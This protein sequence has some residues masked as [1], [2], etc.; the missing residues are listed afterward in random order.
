VISDV[1]GL[2]NDEAARR[3][4]DIDLDAI[5]KTQNRR[6]IVDA[7]RRSVFTLFNADLIGIA[8][9]MAFLQ[10]FLGVLGAVLVII[11]N[12][13]LNAGQ[14]AFARVQMMKLAGAVRPEI[15]VVREG[16]LKTVPLTRVVRGDIVVAGPGDE[17]SVG[18]TVVLNE[19]LKVDE[20][21]VGRSDPRSVD[22]GDV[23]VSGSFVTSGH[24]LYESSEAGLAIQAER[25]HEDV[26]VYSSD[27]TALQR[28]LRGVLRVL[29]A[30][31]IIF[32]VAV[33]LDS[34]ISAREIVSDEYRDAFSIVFG[35]AP[36]SLF[37]ILVV[38][39]AMGL[40]RIA[41]HGAL[42][43]RSS[44]V[45]TL[46]GVSVICASRSSLV[47][48]LSVKLRMIETPEDEKVVSRSRARRVLGDL[49]HTVAAVDKTSQMLRDAID[50]EERTVTDAVSLLTVRGWSG[51]SFDEQDIRGTVVLGRPEILAD[52]L[53]WTPDL[54]G[55]AED[56][57]ADVLA[58]SEGRGV[59]YR[60]LT[61]LQQ[62]LKPK[63]EI[64]EEAE[65]ERV[66]ASAGLAGTTLVLAYLPAKTE[67]AGGS[68][69][70][71]LPDGL[72][73]LA[74]VDVAED[75]RPEARR[76]LG[77]LVDAGIAIKIV[78]SEPVEYVSTTVDDL[79]VRLEGQETMSGA[80][81]SDKNDEELAAALGGTVAF[82]E[83]SAAQKVRV[84]DALKTDGHTVAML[85]HSVSDLA[86]MRHADVS[87]AQLGSD[88]GVLLSA[89]IVLLKES[90]SALRRTLVTGQRIV[91]GVLDT[92]KLYLSQTGSQLLIILSLPLLFNGE[93]PYHPTQGSVI[94]AWT[95]AIPNMFL[96]SWS[97]AGMLT[98]G[99]MRRRLAHFVI[100]AAICTALLAVAA[101]NIVFRLGLSVE[102][103]QTWVMYAL[104]FAGWFRVLF[105][106][107]PTRFWVGG[108][109]LRGDKRIWWLMLATI[110]SYVVVVAVPLFAGWL[111]VA[112]LGSVVPY[113]LA[114]VAAFAW[115]IVVRT[116]WRTRALDW[117]ADRMA[118]PRERKVG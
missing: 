53:A 116:V 102:Q 19:R 79:G 77:G 61:R 12:V 23:L 26:V 93:F 15:V 37:L 25:E 55:A 50:G 59:V 32:S 2:T 63:E 49:V 117:A 71:S 88:A 97:A 47:G 115:A 52:H 86:A 20:S 85:G 21:A 96:A 98:A 16:H 54:E 29:F 5:R 4:P 76:T 92:F 110:S 109:E 101:Q 82:G 67:F 62:W 18:G 51:A 60:A 69:A 75:I 7:V 8:V 114:L 48:G 22:G 68:E 6:F 100:P 14:Q 46:G 10:S 105:L 87:V 44:S 73:P 106:Q 84:L 56:P 3:I 45:E 108:E 35:V 40:L 36:T 74:L 28:I 111:R 34:V 113:V 118:T 17:I 95:I 94:S 83:L 78:D 80:E 11:I 41:D 30:A 89:D 58:L 90:L 38:V 112:S 31:V 57:F 104:L 64:E 13:G 107:P 81:L 24:A 43:Y 72:V 39:Y 1:T 33:A 70:P 9:I 66:R 91:N 99:G 103:E 42:A 65:E 27:Y